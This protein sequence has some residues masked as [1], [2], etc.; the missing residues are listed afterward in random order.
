[1][2][3]LLVYHQTYGHEISRQPGSPVADIAL[4]IGRPVSRV[5]EKVM[6]FRFIDP[7]GQ[8]PGMIGGGAID[9]RVWADFYDPVVA[10][11]DNSKLL[12]EVH[13]LWGV[14]NQASPI[15]DITHQ[16]A[17]LDAEAKRLCSFDLEN[18][19]ARYRATSKSRAAK[20]AVKPVVIREFVRDPL[21]VAIAKVRADFRCEV[22]GC[23]HPTFTDA[24]DMPYCEVHHIQPLVDGGVDDLINVVCLCPTHH[25]EVHLGKAASEIRDNLLM[26][27]Q[28]P[29]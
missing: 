17:I 5:F 22:S 3:G 19:M 24:R 1:M 14:V 2:A 15:E 29:I 27:R 12:T 25:R 18:L 4:L 7:R 10:T 28:A 11:I 20:P 9:R 6:S 26:L 23:S 21:I 8:Q 13:R 16:G